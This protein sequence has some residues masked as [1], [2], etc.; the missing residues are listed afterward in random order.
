MNRTVWINTNTFDNFFV[1]PETT[2]VYHKVTITGN[3]LSFDGVA[4]DKLSKELSI[5]YQ[6]STLTLEV[7]PFYAFM[8]SLLSIVSS[9]AALLLLKKYLD[10]YN[11]SNLV[12]ITF[13][14]LSYGRLL[15]NFTFKKYTNERTYHEA[16]ACMVN[17]LYREGNSRTYFNHNMYSFDDHTMSK[18]SFIRIGR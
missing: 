10:K 14:Q 17:K 6:D 12:D 2:F 13:D 15:G 9:K 18:A 16:C 11:G 8:I 3:T 5:A 4:V 7:L 1:F